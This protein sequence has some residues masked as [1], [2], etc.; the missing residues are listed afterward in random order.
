VPIFTVV[1]INASPQTAEMHE[2]KLR[3]RSPRPVPRRIVRVPLLCVPQ[4]GYETPA[5]GD[6]HLTE[7]AARTV[8]SNAIVC[9]SRTIP[10]AAQVFLAIVFDVASVHTYDAAYSP[11]IDPATV[12]VTLYVLFEGRLEAQV[13]GKE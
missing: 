7:T 4:A 12:V 5:T 10:A 11:D 3:L 9:G 6:N 8:L 1:V 13:D 2:V